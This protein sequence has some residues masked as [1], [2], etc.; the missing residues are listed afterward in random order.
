M[1]EESKLEEEELEIDN[2]YKVI[3]IATDVVF[4]FKRFSHVRELLKGVLNIF[5]C[6]G[7]NYDWIANLKD[8]DKVTLT[9]PAGNYPV[10]YLP[11]GVGKYMKP[12]SD[13]NR[14]I[15]PTREYSP[16]DA[17][18]KVKR[19]N[20]KC[21]GRY[22]LKYYTREIDIQAFTSIRM[23]ITQ[24]RRSDD[25]FDTCKQLT[26]TIFRTLTIDVSRMYRTYSNV[27]PRTYK[28]KR[29]LVG[30]C[31]LDTA[32]AAFIAHQNDLDMIERGGPESQQ[33]ITKVGILTMMCL[34]LCCV[35][36]FVLVGAFL[37]MI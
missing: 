2:T 8:G 29:S 37:S 15:E 7:G 9:I 20:F 14:N 32:I 21:T 10:V 28:V 25:G 4:T 26:Q 12:S 24:M 1:I 27:D 3:S 11:K 18:F 19:R 35:L 5:F 31:V 17:V 22:D 33:G 6:D 36:S 30:N 34:G 16:C 23:A 13:L